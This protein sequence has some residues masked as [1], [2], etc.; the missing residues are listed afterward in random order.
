MIQGGC[1]DDVEYMSLCLTGQIS[2]IH[3][4]ESL[5]IVEG[6]YLPSNEDCVYYRRKLDDASSANGGD[7]GVDNNTTNRDCRYR[8]A[9]WMLKVRE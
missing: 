5:M 3:L 8:I 9:R 6:R 1:Y 7:G 2:C 4:A